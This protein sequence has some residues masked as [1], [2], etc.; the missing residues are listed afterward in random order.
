MPFALKIHWLVRSIVEDRTPELY[1]HA[2]AMLS[3]CEAAMV[4][5]GARLREEELGP[6][7]VHRI[8]RRLCDISIY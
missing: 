5:S 2:M 3:L 7:T 1:E 8:L 6:P 4:N